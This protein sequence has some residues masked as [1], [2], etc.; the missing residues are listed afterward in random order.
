ML[1]WRSVYRAEVEAERKRLEEE[2]A[3]EQEEEERKYMESVVRLPPSP[4][5]LLPPSAFRR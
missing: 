4:L 3:R 5:P 2:F 1:D